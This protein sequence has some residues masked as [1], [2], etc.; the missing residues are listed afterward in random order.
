MKTLLY[1]QVPMNENGQPTL[2]KKE[3]EKICEEIQGKV[4]D[5]YIVVAS[6]F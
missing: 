1:L 4:G 6:P 5:D 3:Y 2:N